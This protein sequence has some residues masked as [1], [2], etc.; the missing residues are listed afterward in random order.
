MRLMFFSHLSVSYSLESIDVVG[1][2][3][4][5]LPSVCKVS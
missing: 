3:V 5:N 1:G 4:R 2:C